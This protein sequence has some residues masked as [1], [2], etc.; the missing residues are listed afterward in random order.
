VCAAIFAKQRQQLRT[1]SIKTCSAPLEKEKKKIH[2]KQRA[3]KV[4]ATCWSTSQ[5]ECAGESN[6]DRTI[7]EVINF[8]EVQC[9]LSS[10]RTIAA[11]DANLHE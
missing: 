11:S 8:R 5:W 6:N 3:A 7:A 2:T 9:D 4:I 1:A 10:G